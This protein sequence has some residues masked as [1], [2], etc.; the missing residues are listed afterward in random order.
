MQKGIWKQNNHLNTE[1]HSSN[2]KEIIR[3]T[4]C[5]CLTRDRYIN[6]L[7]ELYVAIA[8]LSF[9]YNGIFSP[10]F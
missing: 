8:N 10:Y 6:K 3:Y 7:D 5:K 4:T 1:K 2:N 9:L